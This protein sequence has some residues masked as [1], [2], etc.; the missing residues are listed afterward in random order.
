[1]IIR[2]ASWY[3]GVLPDIFH[4]RLCIIVFNMICF[5]ELF[6]RFK[7]KSQLYT[8]D[9]CEYGPW[10]FACLSFA[11]DANSVYKYLY[12]QIRKLGIYITLSGQSG[13]LFRATTCL[14][15]KRGQHST[16][17]ER[18]P[19]FLRCLSHFL[20]TNIL[21]DGLFFFTYSNKYPLT[22]TCIKRTKSLGQQRFL[23]LNVWKQEVKQKIQRK[24]KQTRQNNN[25]T[26]T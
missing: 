20:F 23:W 9:V 6:G 4:K 7:S 17:L 8:Y 16:S 10:Q 5:N 25:N 11:L 13:T 3:V 24:T 2:A 19:A 1:M 14:R 26:N 22:L 18:M 21:V 12:F 15:R